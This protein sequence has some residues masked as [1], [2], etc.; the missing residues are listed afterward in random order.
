MEIRER[1][2]FV[3]RK[4]NRGRNLRTGE[5][6][7]KDG[8]YM[9]RY[10]DE[11]TGRRLAVYSPDLAEL[12][13]K[14]KEIEKDQSEGILTDTQFKNMTLNDL[15]EIHMDTRKLAESTQANY[16]RMWNSLVRNELGQMKVVQVRPSH[17]RLFYSRLSKQKY[18]H[19]TIKFLHNMILPSFEVAVDDDI[20]RKNPAKRTL[21]DYGEPEKKRTALS[22]DQQKNLLNYVKNSEVFHIYL[23]LLQ[24]MIGTGL[25]CGELIGLTWKDVDLKTKT[26]YVNHQLIYKNYGDGCDFHVTM[27][28]TEAG[29]REIPMSKM[30]AKAFETQRRLNFQMGIPRDVKIEGLSN[31]VFMS[32]SGRP[33]M[34]TTV[35]FIL[36]DIVKAYNEEENERA[37]R[38]RRKPEELPHISAHILRHTACTRMAETDLDMKVVQYVMGH[39]NISVTMEVYNHITDR[40]RIEREIAKMDLVQIM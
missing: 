6:Q 16:R 38:E 12:R 15:F 27:P 40:S 3:A 29:I 14:E 33:M 24:V 2:G 30:V 8:L 10:K 21:G 37:K 22:F 13:K 25:R 31:F 4:D 1:N 39:A 28:K 19:S 18:S 17:V 20:I 7:R 32:R 36:R 26:V 23:P 11:R 9:Y 34:P 35:N 5:S